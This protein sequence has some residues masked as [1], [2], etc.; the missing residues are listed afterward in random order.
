M[1]RIFDIKL[2]FAFFLLMIIPSVQNIIRLHFIGEM[3]NEWGFNIASQIQWLNILY[4]IIKEALLVPLFYMLF[5]SYRKSDTDLANSVIN[6]LII[7]FLV[8]VTF[9]IFIFL[10]SHTLLEWVGLKSELLSQAETYIKL[11]SIAILFSI[12]AEYLIVYLATLNKIKEM[13]VFSLMKSL[14][15]MLSDT[16][17]ISSNSLSLN[18]GVNGIAVSN[19][20]INVILT[21]YILFRT[22]L[23]C[24]FKSNHIIFDVEWIKHWFK[25]GAF[26]GLESLVR[27]TVF[28]VMILS[29]MN[30]IGEQGSFWIANSIIW[31]ILLAPSMALAEVV[32]RDVASNIDNIRFKSFSYLLMTVLFVIL[33]LLS[34]PLW[35]MFLSSILKIENDTIIHLMTIQTIFYFVFMLNNSVFD[36]TLTGLGLTKY[37]LWQSIIVNI[38]YYGVVFIL[39]K[40]NVITMNLD[41]IAYVFGGGMIVDMIPTIILYLKALKNNNINIVEIFYSSNSLKRGTNNV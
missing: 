29:M 22:N 5:I 18:L 37:L 27:N 1:N 41:N 28:F 24:Y 32:K 34:M 20:I 2:W 8:H 4:E 9:S 36:A 40:L 26:S 25:T 38:G 15:L 7:V 10:S 23:I 13:V 11:E 19:I 17:I 12:S 16:F 30:Q 35:E 33:W 21:I 14:L 31:G 39:Y 6:G 3:P